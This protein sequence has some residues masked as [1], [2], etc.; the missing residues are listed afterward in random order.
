MVKKLLLYVFFVFAILILISGI[1]TNLLINKIRNSTI[2]SLISFRYKEIILNSHKEVHNLE[3]AVEKFY[4]YLH[5]KNKEKDLKALL[6]S[7]NNVVVIYKGKF[8]KGHFSKD[9]FYMFHYIKSLDLFIGK[10][11]KYSTIYKVDEIVNQINSEVRGEVF[12]Y[13]AWYFL[14]IS[15]IYAL[16]IYI[17]RQELIEIENYIQSIHERSIR[18]ILTGVYNRRALEFLEDKASN[19]S[20][21]VLDLDNFKYVNDTFG[22]K[23]GDVVLI[24]FGKLLRKYFKNDVIIRWGGDEFIIFTEKDFNKIKELS[25]KINSKIEKIQDTFDKDKAKKLSM[26]AGVC[27]DKNLPYEEKFKNADLALYEVKKTQKGGVLLFKEI[28]KEKSKE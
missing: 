14:G 21:I 3:I 12:N 18:D 5:D 16:F 19:K 27:E 1:T 20:L 17:Y 10:G 22:H 26:S 7:L 25:L 11:I 8:L 4:N 9:K 6:S 23:I 24:E 13:I 15:L 2:D 28:K